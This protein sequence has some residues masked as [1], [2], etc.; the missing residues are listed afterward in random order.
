MT[1]MLLV[2]AL[3]KLTNTEKAKGKSME[4]SHLIL[5]LSEG[6]STGL[7]RI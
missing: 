6:L 5:C 7:S 2:L 3:S 1:R 4:K